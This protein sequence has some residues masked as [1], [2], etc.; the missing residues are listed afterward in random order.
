MEKEIFEKAFIDR[1][2][3][4]FETHSE[5]F[6]FKFYTFPELG[7]SIFEINKC[8]ILEFYR[9]SITLTNNVLERVLKLALI[10]NEV[11][12]GPKPI[13]NWN[14]IFSETD[15]YNSYVLATTIEKC[16]KENLITIEEKNILY[17]TIRELM[18]NGFSHSDPSKVLK[19]LPDELPIFQSSFSNPTGIKK[20]NI[21][22]KIIPVFQ[23]IQMDEFA[24]ENAFTYFKFVF[25]LMK[26]IDDRLKLKF[27]I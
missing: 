25:N 24:R 5:F 14:S 23:S 20:V 4:N 17:D 27:N 7:S 19:D 15:K 11:G 26:S 9:A 12:I 22:Q 8:L 1:L 16:K 13:E 3:K 2:N 10:Y 6:E 21:N 18:R